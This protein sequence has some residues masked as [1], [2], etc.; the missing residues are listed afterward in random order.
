[1]NNKLHLPFD[2]AFMPEDGYDLL[3]NG[4]TFSIRD[5]TGVFL[6]TEGSIDVAIDDKRYNVKKNDFILFIPSNF[7]HLYN[8]SKNFKGVVLHSE[9]DFFMNE[10]NKALDMKSQL[11]MMNHMQIPLTDEEANSI[12]K[13]MFYIHQRIQQE[14][15]ND[16]NDNRRIILT[17]LIKSLTETLGLEVINIFMSKFDIDESEPEQDR[18]DEVIRNFIL[19]L[20]NNYHRERSVMFYAQEQ[21]LSYSYFSDIVKK[22]SGLSAKGW[23]IK[24]VINDA[25]SMLE[26][27]QESI[28]EIANRLNFPTQSFFG[29][30]FKQY[31]GMSPK[32]YR[33][34][35]QMENHTTNHGDVKILNV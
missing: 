11:Y 17:K 19:S 32:D 34:Q 22:K 20:N 23:I 7:I 30:Y 35:A 2:F 21:C 8:V 25:K 18:K 5:T 15:K 26:Y 14:N 4:Q 27:T 31:V 33:L 9:V 3:E 1:M 24:Y 6:C 16:L 28:K 10:A 13:L 29:K 12:Y